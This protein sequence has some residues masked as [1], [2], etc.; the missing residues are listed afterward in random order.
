MSFSSIPR[1]SMFSRQMHSPIPSPHIYTLPSTTLSISSGPRLLKGKG[2]FQVARKRDDL[3]TVLPSGWS[4]R[5]ASVLKGDLGLQMPGRGLWNQSEIVGV[6]SGMLCLKP[7]RGPKALGFSNGPDLTT[8]TQN[9]K[10]FKCRLPP[11]N[12]GEKIRKAKQQN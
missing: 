10:I 2:G 7:S 1:A 6:G 12:E 4:W 3:N 11:L 8:T 5:A 9:Q